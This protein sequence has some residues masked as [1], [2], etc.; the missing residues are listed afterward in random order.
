M[1]AASRIAAVCVALIGIVALAG[2]A[3]GSLALAS[4]VPGEP[5]VKPMAALAFVATGFAVLAARARLLPATVAL[6]A[7][8]IAIGAATLIE[9]AADVDLGIDRWL[10]HDAVLAERLRYAIGENLSFPGRMAPLS[11]LAF[12]L[13]GVS[14]V[15]LVRE[16][17]R[18]SQILAFVSLV[19][20]V[21]AVVGFL[22]GTTALSRLGSSINFALPTAIGFTLASFALLF[23]RPAEGPVEIVTSSGAGGRLIRRQL[24]AVL[25]VP[26]V[27]GALDLAA[28]EAGWYEINVAIGIL[29]VILVLAGVAVTLVSAW[30]LESADRS[31][32]E[33]NAELED[34]V[35]AQT[36]EIAEL[37]MRYRSL[38]LTIPA[39]VCV[40]DDTGIRFAN[41]AL[42]DLAGFERADDLIGLE[43]T[44][45]LPLGGDEWYE[46]RRQAVLERGQDVRHIEV[47]AQR[48]DGT[49][50]W[51]AASATAINY[52]GKP[53][54]LAVVMDISD[55]VAARE[56][57][58]AMLDAAPDATVGVD[59][60]GVIAFAN[61]RAADLLGYERTDLIGMNVDELVPDTLRLTHA[62]HRED[63]MREPV[64][65][66]MGARQELHVRLASGALLP[67]E[68]SLNSLEFEGRL[69][70]LAS[71]RDVSENRALRRRLEELSWT[72]PLTGL[73]NRRHFSEEAE[74]LTRLLA[75]HGSTVS[76]LMLD[77]DDFKPINDTL[78]H[79]AGDAM[80]RQ[81][82]GAIRG[83]LRT[84]DLVARYGGDEFVVLLPETG[85]IEAQAVAAELVAGI[86]ACA[87]G[88]PDHEMRVTASVGVATSSSAEASVADMVTRADRALLTAKAQGTATIEVAAD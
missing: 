56:R 48:R 34:R 7:L 69:I 16:R 51:V 36:V 80:L 4:F 53:A 26:I 52:Q 20:G 78:G 49:R 82:A 58:R 63:Y 62:A 8:A 47:E 40:V 50:L 10:F 86:T 11:A 65:R 66:P 57:F 55:R 87:I 70:V 88:G 43:P 59:A 24:P 67:C 83:R 22:Q 21:I 1:R 39:G 9:Y 6:A 13:T 79:D 14:A 74:Q 41:Q 44:S 12:V 75:R 42:A 85:A 71:I 31:L 2:W 17:I 15:M 28:V 64:A 3:T 46:Q 54:A 33:L 81:V 45:F 76:V 77:L 68:I 25:I 30:P 61:T 60:G 29:V 35:H 84:T 73:W 27:A 32:R 37:A 38:L 5:T 72:D 19:I 18:A 23:D